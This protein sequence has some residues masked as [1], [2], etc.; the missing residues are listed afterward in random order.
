MNNNEIL[1]VLHAIFDYCKVNNID[2]AL[3]NDEYTLHDTTE[4]KLGD[5]RIQG[6]FVVWKYSF[7]GYIND[8]KI[9]EIFE[10]FKSLEEF[11][12]SCFEWLDFK[13]NMCYKIH[14]IFAAIQY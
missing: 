9:I 10:P 3:M 14:E 1:L 8:I 7:N 13:K 5:L 4:Y 11:R 6:N 12:I 2:I